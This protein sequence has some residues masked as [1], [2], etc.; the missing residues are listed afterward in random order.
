MT[1]SAQLSWDRAVNENFSLLLA[2]LAKLP[3]GSIVTLK[4][5]GREFTSGSVRL[6][7]GSQFELPHPRL[8]DL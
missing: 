7:D 4:D 1:D 5:N 8:R 3:P 6:P 2:D